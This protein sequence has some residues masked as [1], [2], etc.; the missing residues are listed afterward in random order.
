MDENLTD[1]LSLY[2]ELQCAPPNRIQCTLTGHEMPSNFET[3]LHY[4]QGTKF[5]RTKRL[6]DQLQKNESYFEDRGWYLFCKLTKRKVAK[7]GD[8]IEM[9]VNGRRFQKALAKA[10]S[11]DEN[12]NRME[13]SPSGDFESS[14]EPPFVDASDASDDDDEFVNKND[15]DSNSSS[16]S[17]RDVEAVDNGELYPELAF[18]DKDGAGDSDYDFNAMDTDLDAETAT[19]RKVDGHSLETPA[20]KRRRC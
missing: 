2:P 20:H 13:T 1:L 3:V 9:H 5:Q 7:E 16:S 10:N 15:D 17:L 8:K 12:G 14:P 18:S 6:K 11:A 4:V 19:K